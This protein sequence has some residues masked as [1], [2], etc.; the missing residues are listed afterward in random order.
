MFQFPTFKQ[1]LK[2]RKFQQFLPLIIFSLLYLTSAYRN[3]N[4]PAGTAE[5]SGFQAIKNS[6]LIYFSLAASS[7]IFVIHPPH[8]RYTKSVI[9]LFQIVL[10]INCLINLAGGGQSSLYYSSINPL[11][12]ILY[13]ITAGTLVISLFNQEPKKWQ[14]III[15]WLLGIISTLPL[16]LF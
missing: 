16:L 3:I 12:I 13:L 1:F 7:I 14:T 9:A 4:L 6:I 15:I 5:I 10:G 2:N 8:F 11:I